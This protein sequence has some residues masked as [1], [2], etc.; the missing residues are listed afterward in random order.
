MACGPG[1]EGL[2]LQSLP[3]PRRGFLPEEDPCL[4]LP[5]A[6]A[7]WDELGSE[8]PGLLAAG[9][10]REHIARLP[11][12]EPRLLEEPRHL[13]R[14]MMLLSFF[15][16]AAVW[17]KGRQ[18]PQLSFPRSVAV[19]WMQ[20]AKRLGRPP[21]LAYSSHA[22][23][24]WRR[25]DPQGPIALGNLMV[26]Q[27]FLGGLDESWFI[28]VH[29]NI[30]AQAE[31]IISAAAAAREAVVADTPE[32]LLS[33]L[34]LIAEAQRETERVMLRMTERCEPS[35]FFSRIQP[36]LHGFL[37]MPVVY[38]G[39]EELGGQ[40]QP[41]AGA[42]AAQSMI[43]PLLDAVLGVR[44]SSEDTLHRY[45][46]EL[47]RYIPPAHLAFLEAMEQGPSLREY[48]LSHRSPELVEAYNT[49][50]ELLG[51]FRQKH[52]EMTARYIIQ[53]AREQG[54]SQGE[55]G[56]GGTPFTH[57]LKKHRDETQRN[58]IR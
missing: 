12:L 17:E 25:I 45:L 1:A 33:Q 49:C 43:L 37:E 15:G 27:T 52:M 21:V 31:P 44:H 26:L 23:N 30:E 13:E 41:F 4:R 55:Q 2:S 11:L 56:T 20:V 10:A 8:L 35:I 51:I 32:L 5:E 7:P 50:L 22:L 39:V 36:F 53:P 46:L 58:L 40:P 28:L 29:V 48:I 19:P 14:A 57:Y 54:S 34:L 38:E 9:R 42:S 16:H 47:R 24:N 18:Q 6:F 3:F